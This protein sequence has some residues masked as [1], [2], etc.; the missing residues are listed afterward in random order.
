MR[1]KRSGGLDRAVERVGRDAGQLGHHRGRRAR[2]RARLDEPRAP[3][4]PP[5]LLGRLG[6]RAADDDDDLAARLLGG[7][8][9]GQRRRRR[10]ARPPR[11]PW[12]ARG[13]PR[14]AA[15]GRPRRATPAT[16]PAACGDSNATTVS[17]ERHTTAQLARL[18][19]QEADEP[20]RLGGQR[21]R[22]QRGERRAR[23]GQHLDRHARRDRAGH[24]HVARVADQRHPGV[25]DQRDHRPRRPS[26]RR[27]RPP[28]P[29]RCARG[30][31]RACAVTP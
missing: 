22:H 17:G 14:P 28:A 16:P 7:V 26:A 9:L 29:A 24:E 19:R 10:R 27:A 1:D 31:R 18:A 20:P 5:A 21:R 11:G 4:R 23:P 2:L 6:R 15:P 13:T 3:R 25:A 8:A 12:S 30:R